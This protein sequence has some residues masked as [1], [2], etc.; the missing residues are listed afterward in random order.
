MNRPPLEDAEDTEQ[1][2]DAHGEGDR[3]PQA[4]GVILLRFRRR[5]RGF[6]RDR[7]QRRLRHGRPESEQKGESQQ[8]EEAAL[9]GQRPRHCLSDGKQAHLQALNEEGEAEQNQH[10]SDEYAVEVRNRLLQHDQLEERDDHDDGRQIAQRFQDQK[11]KCLQALRHLG[12][13]HEKCATC[14]ARG[15]DRGNGRAQPK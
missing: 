5:L 7:D 9:A 4:Q 14:L 6:G 2:R 13:T 1:D 12:F 10:E 3:H 11:Q 8:P 15:W